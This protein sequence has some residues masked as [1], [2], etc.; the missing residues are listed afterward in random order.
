MGEKR[1]NVRVSH[2]GRRSALKGSDANFS[3]GVH[4]MV[5]YEIA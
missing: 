2:L 4:N 5:K 1:E 3:H